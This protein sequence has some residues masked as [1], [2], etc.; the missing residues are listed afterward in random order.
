MMQGGGGGGP[1]RQVYYDGEYCDAEELPNGF[2]KIRNGQS[3]RLYL[4]PSDGST[5]HPPK[6]FSRGGGSY[7]VVGPCFFIHFTM[8]S[9]FSLGQRY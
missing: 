2:T 6:F 4:Q 9:L 7:F 3:Y 8:F 1:Q 5:P